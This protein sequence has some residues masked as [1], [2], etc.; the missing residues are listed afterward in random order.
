MG[1]LKGSSTEPI[2][3]STRRMVGGSLRVERRGSLRLAMRGQ[4]I[5]TNYGCSL[6]RL[7]I[8]MQS[9]MLEMACAS[10]LSRDW[11]GRT[12]SLHS[13]TD[14]SIKIRGGGFFL[15]SDG[16]YVLSNAKSGRRMLARVGQ[17]GK[18]WFGAIVNNELIN[19]DE[20][21]WLINQEKDDAG[22]VMIELQ[23][24]RNTSIRLLE[25]AKAIKNESLQVWSQLQHQYRREQDLQTEVEACT[26]YAG[27]LM[28]ELADA[29]GASVCF[30]HGIQNHTAQ[31]GRSKSDPRTT[32]ALDNT[33]KSE[34]GSIIGLTKSCAPDSPRG[35]LTDDISVEQLASQED[36]SAHQASQQV[37]LDA[38]A[39]C[40]SDVSRHIK[41]I[42]SLE[43]ESVSVQYLKSQLVDEQQVLRASSSCSLRESRLV[44]SVL[45]FGLTCMTVALVAALKHYAFLSSDVERK[46]ARIDELENEFAAEFGG[47]VKVGD[48]MGELG[49]DFGFQIFDTQ[50]DQQTVRLVKIQCPGA[51]HADVELELIFNGCKVTICR[52]ASQG[53]AATTWHKRFQFRPSDGLFEF[54]EDQ[55]QLES[56][57]LQLVF[58][59]YS[60]QSRVIRF[61]LHFSLADTDADQ[62]WEF[63]ADDAVDDADQGEACWH[64]SPK[65]KSE[66][67]RGH[68]VA[69]MSRIGIDVDT[70][71]TASTI[72]TSS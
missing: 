29:R 2:Q 33:L 26:H 12:A 71:S 25:E 22:R 69:T 4:F 67:A 18:T 49:F 61:P 56:G 52:Q 72:Q 63:S 36:M 48:S 44:E 68:L 15:Q 30:A 8:A 43:A 40:G 54:K 10:Q 1:S 28:S 3:S 45:G 42:E 47:M 53:V 38:I 17:D 50:R 41:H 20:T 9:S 59:A 60:F 39:S 24:E 7:T 64:G 34:S 27:R 37:E 65:T 55:M 5:M 35:Q 6:R 66:V 32:K 16:S 57:F 14:P 13:T 70:D 46:R 51:R 23:I 21:W 11:M 62:C 58:R 31:V 19:G